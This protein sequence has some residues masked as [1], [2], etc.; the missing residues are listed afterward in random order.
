MSKILIFQ[1]ILFFLTAL[2][3]ASCNRDGCSDKDALNYEKSAKKDDGSCTYLT[4]LFTGNYSGNELCSDGN[5]GQEVLEIRRIEG[6]SNKILFNNFTR[7]SISPSAL[8]DGNN[9]TIPSQSLQS[10]LLTIN[11]SGNGSVNNNEI[12]IN[13]T[14]SEAGQSISCNFIGFK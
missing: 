5:E 4:D 10:A 11:V 1:S 7:Y 6:E 9:F 13:Y 2:I 12:N 14:L 3:A 8:I